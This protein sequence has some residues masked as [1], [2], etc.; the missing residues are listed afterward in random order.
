MLKGNKISLH[1][2]LVEAGEG[3]MSGGGHGFK[4]SD[5]TFVRFEAGKTNADY[6]I[7]TRD[8]MGEL[9]V[10]DG[11]LQNIFKKIYDNTLVA[12]A[13]SVTLAGL[14][15]DTD[16]EY[17]MS[18]NWIKNGAALNNFGVQC[19]ADAGVASYGWQTHFGAGGGGAAV[20]NNDDTWF[21]LWMGRADTD[22]YLSQGFARLKA[23]SGFPRSCLGQFSRE[24]DPVGKTIAGYYSMTDTWWNT[25]ANLTSLTFLAEI[26]VGLKIGTEIQ[27]WKR[28]G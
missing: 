16:E 19:N 18:I 6:G 23:V 25:I 22:G 12:N 2:G 11:I 27:V 1:G 26:A 28:Q 15:G 14:D 3:V 4:V 17:L 10:A 20:T 21:M 5:G 9:T 8:V 24:V 7:I 13:T